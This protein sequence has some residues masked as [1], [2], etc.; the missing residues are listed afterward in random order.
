MSH[1]FFGTCNRLRVT[2]DG[3]LKVCLFGEESCSL[4]GTMRAGASDS[5]IVEE[6]GELTFDSASLPSRLFH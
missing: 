4:L 2:A 3:K 1:N 5:Q 6:I